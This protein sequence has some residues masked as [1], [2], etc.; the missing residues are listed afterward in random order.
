MSA[1]GYR[2]RSRSPRQSMKQPAPSIAETS[3]ES[4][5][6]AEHRQKISEHTENEADKVSLKAAVL[7]PKKK[8][9]F[10]IRVQ[11]LANWVDET[12]IR[13]DFSQAGEIVDLV[14]QDDGVKTAIVEYVSESQAETA[15]AWNGSRWAGQVISVCLA[16]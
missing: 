11:G 14:L 4:P 6:T 15:L 3:S 12:K 7:T 2:Q 1:T 10:A 13:R 9:P 8:G 16:S 5:T